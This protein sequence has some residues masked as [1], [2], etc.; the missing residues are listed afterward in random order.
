[1]SVL[2]YLSFAQLSFEFLVYLVLFNIEIAKTKITSRMYRQTMHASAASLPSGS[3]LPCTHCI[4]AAKQPRKT[5]IL[6]CSNTIHH[7]LVLF[8]IR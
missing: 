3:L 1:M 5:V 2:S 4:T 6:Y 7:S 8:T